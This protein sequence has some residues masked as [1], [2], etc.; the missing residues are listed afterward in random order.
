M[1]LVYFHGPDPNLRIDTLPS[2]LAPGERSRYRPVTAGGHSAGKI[3]R[4]VQ[5]GG[6]ANPA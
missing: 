2:C 1:P 3:S 5:A 6:P 4:Q